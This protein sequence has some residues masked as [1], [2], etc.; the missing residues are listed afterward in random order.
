M[1]SRDASDRRPERCPQGLE[2]QGEY[3]AVLIDGMRQKTPVERALRIERKGEALS[4]DH[5][6]TES[7]AANGEAESLAEDVQLMERVCERENLKRALARVRRNKGAPGADRMT[8]DEL[9]GY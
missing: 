9:P 5:Q 3:D 6:G 1:R 4:A 8:V 2:W 7:S